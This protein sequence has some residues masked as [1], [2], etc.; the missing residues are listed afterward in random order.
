V[1]RRR[2]PGLDVHFK[3]TQAALAALLDEYRLRADDH[4]IMNVTGGFKGI[5]A[6]L[7]LLAQKNGWEMYFQHEMRDS[8]ALLHFERSEGLPPS[9][10]IFDGNE[11]QQG[12]V[13]VT[14]WKP[15]L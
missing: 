5:I 13:S 12:L 6:F 7:T 2:I 1:E 14:E 8:A 10:A 4:V 15:W 9:T 11:K 3:N